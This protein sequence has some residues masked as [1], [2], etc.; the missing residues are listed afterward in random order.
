VDI[1]NIVEDESD[2]VAGVG[3]D[4]SLQEVVVSLEDELQLT[5]LFSLK[6][7]QHILGTIDDEN[8]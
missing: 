4:L 7:F 6:G 2:F 5:F 8:C 3:D 1:Y